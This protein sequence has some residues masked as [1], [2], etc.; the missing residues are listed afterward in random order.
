MY[1]DIAGHTLRIVAMVSNHPG[2]G[3]SY[4]ICIS[5]MEMICNIRVVVAIKW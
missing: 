2:N 1:E 4:F 5:G 3:C